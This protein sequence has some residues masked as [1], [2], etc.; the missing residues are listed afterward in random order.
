MLRKNKHILLKR[1]ITVIRFETCFI[2]EG[3]ELI[4]TSRS[5]G[6]FWLRRPGQGDSDHPREPP[7]KPREALS[8]SEEN[9]LLPPFEVL[10]VANNEV[11]FL[12]SVDVCS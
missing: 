6:S 5:C 9:H 1:L 2:A 12:F 7:V 10:L 3:A 4:K 11:D 8:T